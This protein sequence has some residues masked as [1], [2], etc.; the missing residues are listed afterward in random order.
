MGIHLPE[1]S[2]DKDPVVLEA[3]E[4]L[5]HILTTVTE[6]KEIFVPSICI[7]NKL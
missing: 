5:L 7:K 1:A 4:L 3:L 6:S 2:M